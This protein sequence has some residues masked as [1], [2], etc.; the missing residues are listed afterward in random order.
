ATYPALA[1]QHVTGHQH[2][3]PERKTDPGPFF[4]WERLG[5]A[6]EATLPAAADVVCGGPDTGIVRT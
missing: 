6:L 4:D 3:A 2:I 5:C 1:F